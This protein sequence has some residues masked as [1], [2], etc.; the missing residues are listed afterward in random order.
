[1]T[2]TI[3]I[4]IKYTQKNS[5]RETIS[6]LLINL[7]VRYRESSEIILSTFK[8]HIFLLAYSVILI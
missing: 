5:Y 7:K 6:Y 3:I 4:I 8:L 2:F 1:M